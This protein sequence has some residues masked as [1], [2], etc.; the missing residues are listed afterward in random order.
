MHVVE[1]TSSWLEPLRSVCC[2][3]CEGLTHAPLDQHEEGIDCE[4]MAGEM[5]CVAPAEGRVPM[6]AS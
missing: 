3:A 4:G 5:A 1:Q 6:W 2:A